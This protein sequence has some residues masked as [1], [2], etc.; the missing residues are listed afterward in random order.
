MG[1]GFGADEGVRMGVT[2][3]ASTSAMHQVEPESVFE[4]KPMAKPM[5]YPACGIELKAVTDPPYSQCQSE[6][7][8]CTTASVTAMTSAKF[9]LPRANSYVDTTTA[10]TYPS[11]F[12]PRIT[13]LSST[14]ASLSKEEKR[15]MRHKATL[16]WREKIAKAKQKS[17]LGEPHAVSARKAATA[18]RQRENGRFK[19]VSTAWISVSEFQNKCN[20][21]GTGTYSSGTNTDS[22]VLISTEKAAAIQIYDHADAKSEY[23][24]FIKD[25]AIA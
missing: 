23:P 25:E 21:N 2:R 10:A 13:P 20:I 7:F 5:Q 3:C 22:Q 9:P 24:L 17:K 14:P 18:K 11:K 6:Q 19:K 15:S 16:R 1:M 8:H 12:Q 4:M